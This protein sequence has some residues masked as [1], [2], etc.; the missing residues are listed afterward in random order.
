MSRTRPDLILF[1]TSLS[2]R[3]QF[4]T[5]N[6]AHID[7][8]PFDGITVNIPPGWSAMSPGN[9][10]T[11]AD[12]ETWLE[13]LRAFNQ[14]RDNWLTVHIDDPG[15]VF[16]DTAW[17]R[18][19]QNWKL[20]AEVAKEKDFDGILFDNE[21]YQGRLL[22]WPED[23]PPDVVAR[24]L[25]AYQDQMSLRGRQIAEAVASVW[26]DAKIAFTHGP[27]ISVQ[28]EPGAPNQ[29]GDADQHE[30]A[31]ALFTGFLEGA[32]ANMRIVD[33]GE[34]YSLRTADDYARFFDYRSNALPGQIDWNV[35]PDIIANWA[36][37]VDQ[38][39]IVYT[40]EYPPGVFLTPQTLVSTLLNAFDHSEGAVYLFTEEDNFDWLTPGELPADW[41]AAARRAV[42][43]ADHTISGTNGDNT[44]QGGPAANRLMGYRGDD[45]LAGNA[46]ADWLE[47]RR[48][49]DHLWGGAGNDD[50]LG[51]RGDDTLSGGGGND[52]LTG[53][54]G[55]DVF[56]L[57]RHCG[58][59]R[60]LDFNPDVDRIAATGIAQVTEVDAGLRVTLGDASLLLVGLHTADIDD[61]TFI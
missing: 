25:Q 52:R 21:E 27:Y 40:D 18:V 4:I 59:D 48:G 44:L 12:L 22:N 36:A 58:A 42:W 26:D 6:E 11:R 20:M 13:P 2:A 56:V 43:L 3:T 50:L 24:G 15:D 23:Y 31:G 7:T 53:G 51:G 33:G 8:L 30:L 57:R 35:D 46:G 38:T 34:L 54:T 37:R 10:V 16:N 55:A 61:I 32:S 41:L 5:Q 60:V 1:M 49:A 29:W 28:Q 14:G 47:G 45:R 39:T 9:R 17:T 19:V